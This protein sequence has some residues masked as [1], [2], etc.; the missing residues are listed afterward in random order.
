MFV[1]RSSQG[2]QCELSAAAADRVS[3]GVSQPKQISETR[4]QLER[5]P[6]KLNPRPS[7]RVFPELRARLKRSRTDRECDG[8]VRGGCVSWENLRNLLKRNEPI[9]HQLG[10]QPREIN[11]PLGTHALRQS[12]PAIIAVNVFGIASIAIPVESLSHGRA[13]QMRLAHMAQTGELLG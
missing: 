3:S 12:T 5:G 1:D 8:G 4:A 6:Q 9:W 2:E 10:K 13:W 11:V 7:G